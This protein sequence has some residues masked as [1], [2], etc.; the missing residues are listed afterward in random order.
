[1]QQSSSFSPPPPGQATKDQ[2]AGFF[3]EAL[4]ESDAW[5]A[6]AFDGDEK[7]GQNDLF[8]AET[9][10]RV[11]AE[12]LIHVGQRK[13]FPGMP[14]DIGYWGSPVL[15]FTPPEQYTGPCTNA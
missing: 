5:D 8:T 9:V 10:G 14:D 3:V 2:M 13:D 12:R 11:L 6:C 15:I 4:M 1:M 7:A